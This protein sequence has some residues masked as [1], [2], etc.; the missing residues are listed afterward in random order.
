[1]LRVGALVVFVGAKSIGL[2]FKR[3]FRLSWFLY[4]FHHPLTLMRS[5]WRIRWMKVSIAGAKLDARSLWN[6]ENENI[7]RRLTCMRERLFA[8][9]PAANSSVNLLEV[10]LQ[11]SRAIVKCKQLDETPSKLQFWGSPSPSLKLEQLEC[12]GG[13]RL[14]NLY[15]CRVHA[16]AIMPLKPR[17]AQMLAIHFWLLFICLCRL[18]IV[19]NGSL[20]CAKKS[21]LEIH[22]PYVVG[23]MGP[24]HMQLLIISAPQ[25]VVHKITVFPNLSIAATTGFLIS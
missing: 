18:A 24:P 20:P 25:S 17:L 15:K 16:N 21:S 9:G 22:G 1:M 19:L 11:S 10:V 23:G 3:S 13:L 5:S 6:R 8:L 7:N 14:W 2:D 12:K 4:T